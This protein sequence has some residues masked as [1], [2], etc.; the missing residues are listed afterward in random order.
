VKKRSI[1]LAFIFSLS[2]PAFVHAD[3]WPSWRGPDGNGISKEA[4]LPTTWSQTKN[5]VWKL[6]LPGK[7]SSTPI[8]WGERIF[9]T[10]ADGGDIVLMCIST[11]GK[12]LWKHKL[13]VGNS[14]KKN[15]EGN[16]ASSTPCT[17]GKHVFAYAGTG[18]FACFDFAGNEI[19]KFNAQERY[20]KFRIQHGMH[21]TPLLHEDKL[22]FALIHNNGHWL[23]A[24]D[25]KTGNEVWKVERKSDAVDES[26]EAYTSPCLWQNGSELNLVVLGADYT[27]G[28]RLKDGSEVWRLGDLNP[29]SNY[30]GAFR[31]IASPVAGPDELLVPT[32]RDG[33]VVALKPGV[34]G[35]IKAGNPSEYWRTSK[36]SPDVPS[37]LLYDGL[38]YLPRENGVLICRDAKTGKLQY[39]EQPIRETI[40]AS[41]IIADGKIYHVSRDS[42]TISVIKA[43]REYKLLATNRLPD[44]FYASPAVSGGRLYLRG[45]RA[46]YAIQENAK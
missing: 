44:E 6:P 35:M 5:L 15:R 11:D 21:V 23:I 31:I 28:H 12:V 25:K 8:I 2:I 26:R 4:G 3:N 37:P 45:F 43:G 29:K 33:L 10:A 36:G 17:D 7:G 22:Y 39:E 13:A 19:W 18:D 9:L 41:P 1:V 38:A 42:G 20:G 24:L 30:S 32:C 34:K 46:L 27:T 16:E 40:R 14:K